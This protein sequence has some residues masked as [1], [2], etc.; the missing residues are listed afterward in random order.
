M[1]AFVAQS[2]PEAMLA[3]LNNAFEFAELQSFTSYLCSFTLP[4]RIAYVDIVGRMR[5]HNLP[6]RS[7][8]CP[9]RS[10]LALT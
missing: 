7:A 6:T 8:R 1:L 2:F 10:V 3:P 9:K 4:T 5:P